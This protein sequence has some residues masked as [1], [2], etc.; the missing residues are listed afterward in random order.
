MYSYTYG[1]KKGKKSTLK[2]SP[3][4]VVVRTKNARSLDTAIHS[5]KAKRVLQKFQVE[6]N[7]PEA[8]VCILQ[9]KPTRS[10]GVTTG[11]KT[12]LRDTAR[13]ILKEEPELRFA[14][15][16]LVDDKADS[17][18]LYTENLFIKFKDSLAIDVGETLL[19]NW[20]LK[21]K[22]K[23]PYAKN[24]YFASAPDDTGLEIFKLC[25]NLLDR[26]EVEY[27]H[28]ELVQHCPRKEL[29]HKQWH[30]QETVI[31][32]QK[33]QAHSNVAKAHKI[34]KGKGI[35]IAI[36]DDGVDID[37]MEF[38]L[39]GKV[40]G[41]RDVTL[42]SNDPRPKYWDE[43]HGTACAGVAVAA[44]LNASGVAPEAKLM[45]IRL[46]SVLGSMAEAEAFYWAADKGADIISCSWGPRD[47]AWY[48]ENDPAHQQYHPIPDSTR[49]AIEYA[50]TKGRGGKG[51]IIC[52]A[53]GNGRESVDNDGYAS[54]PNVIAVGASN[55]SGTRS[56]YSDYGKAI[57]CV[58]P[59]GDFKY[60]PF[61]Q[62][63][64]LTRGIYTTDRRGGGGYNGTDYT[65]DF[66]G[67]S[68]ATPGVAGV[69]ALML[70]L[71]PKL[72]SKEVKEMVAVACVK[73]DSSKGEYN[74]KGHSPFY[75]YGKLDALVA[76]QLVKER[77]K[78]SNTTTTTTSTSGC[79]TTTTSTSDT[80][81]VAVVPIRFKV[82]Q[83]EIVQALVNPKGK[84]AGNETVVIRNNTSKSVNLNKWTLVDGKNRTDNLTGL[85][86]KK[87][88]V[89][90]TLNKVKLP[91]RS[92][93][94]VLKNSRG[95]QMHKV[96]YKASNVSKTTGKV[97]FAKK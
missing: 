69:V 18:I 73:I 83:V 26:P 13:K 2:I 4:R 29:H 40:V 1:G 7:F 59:S 52:W 88:A 48:S 36:V 33:I 11:K 87:S 77:M 9:A 84:D 51:C 32:G 82:P 95:K 79:T 57:W 94:L 21:I 61:G 14:G 58:F 41:S 15:R 60:D 97:I 34:A 76:V 92:G 44:G 37:H 64:P 31:N 63:A 70:Q 72:T 25:N 49:L 8:D 19:E 91:N 67:T 78:P 42:S 75:G 3:N 43:N 62:A 66:T 55:D 56:V 54:N 12:A 90:I 96:S 10:R 89:R 6:Q 30:L 23:V 28:P 74:S 65:D 20:D 22:R 81:S 45:P 71:N 17:P 86:P 50:V 80:S 93:V 46:A 47:G 27:C 16:V 39:P 24:A 35:T 85:L 38:N 68:S 5:A 53:A